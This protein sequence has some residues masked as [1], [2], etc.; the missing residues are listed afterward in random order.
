MALP[1]SGQITL[2]QVNVE[3]GNSG[4]A[5]IGLGDTAVR[6][7]FEISSG[8]I[9]MSDGYGKSSNKLSLVPT[10]GGTTI[11]WDGLSNLTLSSSKEYTVTA[12]AT[13]SVAVKMWGGGGARGFDY[14]G[15]F[16]N[17]TNMGDG[18][19]GGFAGGTIAFVKGSTY[20][21]QVGE[22]GVRTGTHDS[23]ATWQA[24]G[25]APHAAGKGGPQGGGYSGIFS[26][27]ASQGNALLIAGGGGGGSSTNWS[28]NGGAGGGSSGQNAADNNQG[29]SGGTQSAGGAA[30]GYN[31]ATAGSALRG[32]LTANAS[33]S[34]QHNFLGGGGGGYYGGGGGNVGGGGGGSGYFKTSSPVSS[35][36]TV[37]GSGAN[38]GNI[39]ESLRSGAGDGGSSS[40]GSSGA[41]GLI[42]LL[43]P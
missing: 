42:V 16:P 10:G 33:G 27:S 28:A 25:I 24:G 13:L 3:L 2:N 14:N 40:Q 6:G 29:G 37:V 41:D 5:Q 18:G 35:G 26:S 31:G 11:L 38:P 32:G 1:S 22:G 19:G 39:S 43:G 23:G 34:S 21:F 30:A 8:E 7:L 17:S 36:S 12:N 9:E 20:K 4:T 15:T